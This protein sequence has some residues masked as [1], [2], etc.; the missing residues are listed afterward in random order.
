MCPDVSSVP[1]RYD[2]YRTSSGTWAFDIAEYKTD[3]ESLIP[4]DASSDPTP[5]EAYRMAVYLEGFIETHRR[6][7]NWSGEALDQFEIFESTLEFEA[8]ATALREIAEGTGS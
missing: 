1:K 4:G 6:A 2:Q 7:S 5:E 8:V 3:L